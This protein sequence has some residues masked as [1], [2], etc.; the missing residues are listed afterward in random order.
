MATPENVDD[1]IVAAT[2]LPGGI[3]PVVAPIV[4]AAGPTMHRLDYS[5]TPLQQGVE[6]HEIE[7]RLR[8][9]QEASREA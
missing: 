8:E 3:E 4:C 9:D 1:E 6:C 2:G 5:A 7:S